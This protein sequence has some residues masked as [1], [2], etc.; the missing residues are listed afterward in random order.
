MLR[1]R[2]VDDVRIVGQAVCHPLAT[3]PPKCVLAAAC[4]SRWKGWGSHSRAN[5]TM[6]SRLTVRGGKVRLQPG[7][8]SS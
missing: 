1:S 2:A 5:R 3:R 6:S 7:T 4:S 8:R